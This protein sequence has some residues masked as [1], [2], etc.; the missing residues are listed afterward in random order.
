MPN[1]DNIRLWVND[2]RSGEFEQGTGQL[3]QV[4]DG[5]DQYCCLGVACETARKNG[6]RMSVVNDATGDKVYDREQAFLPDSVMNWLGL[7]SRNPSFKGRPA[8]DW[9]DGNLAS[10]DE[11]AAL[12]EAEYLNGDLANA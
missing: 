10:L 9:N 6:L 5:V 3:N 12:V 4:K 1:L 7:D 11:I 8:T 2:L